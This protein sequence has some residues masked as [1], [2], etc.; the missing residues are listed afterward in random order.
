M[1]NKNNTGTR[2]HSY[3]QSVCLSNC[4]QLKAF[5]KQIMQHDIT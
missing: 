5:Y 4:S 2:A 3:S 1:W